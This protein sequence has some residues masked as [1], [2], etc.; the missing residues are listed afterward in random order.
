M[1]FPDEEYKRRD[2]KHLI[3]KLPDYEK[4][5]IRY[6]SYINNWM[7]IRLLIFTRE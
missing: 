4:S 5:F 1:S 3:F 2:Q 7:G 6:H